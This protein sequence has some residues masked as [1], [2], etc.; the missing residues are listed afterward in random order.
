MA[1]GPLLPLPRDRYAVLRAQEDASA[2]HHHGEQHGDPNDPIYLA[3]MQA[4]RQAHGR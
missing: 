1:E 3:M 4:A 2:R